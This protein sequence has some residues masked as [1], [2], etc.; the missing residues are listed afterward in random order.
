M[1][2]EHGPC[3]PVG[4]VYEGA[5][6]RRSFVS[7]DGTVKEGRHLSTA[8]VAGRAEEAAATSSRDARGCESDRMVVVP[9]VD[10]HVDEAGMR[11]RHQ[12]ERAS[13]ERS[14]MGAFDRLV[15]TE[16]AL[17]TTSGDPEIVHPF[18]MGRPPRLLGDIIEGS[19]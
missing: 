14:H 2:L 3:D 19:R 6:S 13:E 11:P 7:V 18:R 17:A 12:A 16:H 1:H 9:V 15:G 5:G 4:V 10:A 8:R